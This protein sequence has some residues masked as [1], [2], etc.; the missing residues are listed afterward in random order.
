VSA[1]ARPETIVQ[2]VEDAFCVW[3]WLAELEAIVDRQE[4]SA[5][6]G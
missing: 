6:N 5:V 3:R 1:D 2:E 4:G